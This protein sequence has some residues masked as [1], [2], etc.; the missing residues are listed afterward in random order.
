MP[1]DPENAHRYMELF[2]QEVER[3]WPKWLPRLPGITP[4]PKPKPSVSKTYPSKVVDIVDSCDLILEHFSDGDRPMMCHVVDGVTG[5]AFPSL[6]DAAMEAARYVY[7][8]TQKYGPEWGCVFGEDPDGNVVPSVL[9]TQN[10]VG[11]MG[12]CLIRLEN[13]MRW[14]VLGAL[15]SHPGRKEYKYAHTG[16]SDGDQMTADSVAAGYGRDYYS[17]TVDLPSGNVEYY[18]GQAGRKWDRDKTGLYLPAG[19]TPEN[20]RW[21]N[22]GQIMV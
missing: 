9:V 20:I 2:D 21:G 7:D 4:K 6:K 15:H 19:H 3:K 12:S 11:S 8:S 16:P 1:F 10:L 13:L 22:I 5:V 18:I 14:P 17:I